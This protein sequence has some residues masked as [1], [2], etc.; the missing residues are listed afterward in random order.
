MVKTKVK[1]IFTLLNKNTSLEKYKKN[2]LIILF[3][4]RNS[5]FYKEY[6]RNFVNNTIDKNNILFHN[7]KTAENSSIL[8]WIRILS[9]YKKL[10]KIHA[11]INNIINKQL[12]N[13]A[14]NVIILIGMKNTSILL[15]KTGSLYQLSK[16]YSSTI[17]NMCKN[18]T[19]TLTYYRQNLNNGFESNKSSREINKILRTLACKLLISARLDNFQIKADF[20]FSI[21]SRGIVKN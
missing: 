9:K 11:I 18:F 16:L 7:A 20:S 14:P 12:K 10:T 21:I 8:N 4:K 5:R 1:S 2:L 17:Q 19:Q 6:L 15:K 3:L 13:I